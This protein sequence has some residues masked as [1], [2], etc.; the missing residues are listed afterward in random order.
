MDRI[1][2][3]LEVL[4]RPSV[5]C[6]LKFDQV[7]NICSN[8]LQDYASI[9][10]APEERNR[11]ITINAAHLEYATDK[12]HYAHVDC[13]GHADFVKVHSRSE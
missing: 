13:P 2:G 12:R 8:F 7:L 1:F 6:I 3:A 10:N 11:G 5:T 4:S 9:D